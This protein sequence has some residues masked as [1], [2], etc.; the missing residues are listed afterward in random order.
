MVLENYTTYTEVDVGADR[1]QKTANHIDFEAVRGEVTYL[2]DDKDAVHFGDFEHTVDALLNPAASLSL[3]YVWA[4]TNRIGGNNTCRQAEE[5][6][7]DCGFRSPSAGNY[8]LR[9]GHWTGEAY[10]TDNYACALDT[11]YYLTLERTDTTFTCKIYDAPERNVPDLLDTLTL[12]VS[13]ETY[14]YVYACQNYD[15]GTAVTAVIDIDDLD[16]Q[17]EVIVVP[18]VTTQAATGLTVGAGTLHG[19]ITVTGGENADERGFDW[20]YDSG[21]PYAY[22]ETDLGDFGTG[23]FEEDMSGFTEGE[24]VYFRAKATNSAGWGYGGE[25]SFKVP[26]AWS[27]TVTDILGLTDTSASKGAFK[28]SVSDILGMLESSSTVATFHLTVSDKLGLLESTAA[29]SDLKQ[30]VSEIL[31]VLDTTSLRADQKLAVA[32]VLGI[33][34][35]IGTVKGLYETIVETLGMV[36]TVPLIRADFKAEITDLIGLLDTTTG[37]SDLK[38]TV[39]DIMGLLDTISASAVQHLVVTEILGMLDTVTKRSDYKQ[40]IADSLE[41]VDTIHWPWAGILMVVGTQGR[42]IIISGMQ[43][44]LDIDDKRRKQVIGEKKYS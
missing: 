30:A 12:E 10:N 43:R 28:Q 1:I 2:Y 4:L 8:V 7:I 13:N 25:E 29:K 15:A 17:E 39:S 41:M 42:G 44:G 5:T 16:L 23:A 37:R 6:F 26:K 14:Q 31:G 20:D 36:D 24:T 40:E 38:Q 11:T 19:T 32:E 33:L 9:I 3:G 35:D 22:E 21:A 34:D 18:T 27:E